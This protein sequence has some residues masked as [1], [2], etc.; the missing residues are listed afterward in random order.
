MKTPKSPFSSPVSCLSSSKTVWSNSGWFLEDKAWRSWW[1]WSF[2]ALPF[3]LWTKDSKMASIFRIKNKTNKSHNFNIKI[4]TFHSMY[5]LFQKG[6]FGIHISMGDVASSPN[7]K[8]GK[9]NLA[10]SNSLYKAIIDDNSLLYLRS[11]PLPP[12]NKHHQ[13]V[14]I[15]WVGTS[16][17]LNL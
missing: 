6:Q 1:I 15:F 17:L 2:F 13:H 14:Y 8:R 9:Y 16:Q 7:K 12:R 11:T 5:C 4:S 10:F 3:F